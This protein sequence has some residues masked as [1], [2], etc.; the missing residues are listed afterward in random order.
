[1]SQETLIS[2]KL[3]MCALVIAGMFI[4]CGIG[5]IDATTMVTL[6]TGLIGAL[7]VSLGLQGA[8]T[9]V[10]TAMQAHTRALIAGLDAS[11]QRRPFPVPKTG[12]AGFGSL[13]LLVA[14]TGCVFWCAG[15]ALIVSACTKAQG[16][17]VETIGENIA[18]CAL[19]TAAAD[20]AKGVTDEGQIATDVFTACL[21]PNATDAEKSQVLTI[22]EAAKKL[23]LA[24]GG[25]K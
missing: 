22:L 5:R 9:A 16:A 10:A 8:G 14:M 24:K 11:D 19:N 13:H 1:M 6:T 21:G 15:T 3:G 2:L 12:Q 25:E 20:V 17:E 18:T 7:T 23:S 4:L